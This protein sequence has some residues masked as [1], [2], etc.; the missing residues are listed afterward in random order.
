MANDQKLLEYLKRVTAD[1]DRTR[2]R[3]YE[4]VEREQEPI[5]IVGMAC[6]YP[7]GVGSP[8]DLWE[9]VDAG[10]DAIGEFPTDRGWDL[11]GLYDPD[12]DR[13]G[14]SYTRHG[15]FLYDAG[16]FDA[17]FFGISP[18]EA[19]AM[20]PQ[21]RLLLETA[22]QALE[23]AGIDPTS[24]RGSQTG[25]FAGVN[26]QDYTTD[27]HGRRPD[28]EGYLLTGAAASIASGRISYTFGLEGPAVTID[29]ACSSSLVAL[30]LACQA[31]RAGECTMAFAGGASVLSTPMVFIE[32]A[33]HHGLSVD[34]RCKAFSASADGTGWSEGAGMLLL[35][36][37]SDAERN[38]RRI[39]ALVRGSAVNQDGAS[40]GLTAP[41]GPSQRRVIRQ[42]LTNAHLAPADIDAVEGHGTGTR[43]GDPIEVQALQE[44]YGEDRPDGRPLWLG[45]LK[46]NIGHSIAAAGVGSVIKM[47]MALRHGVLPRTLHAEE[48]SPHIDWTSGAVQL[49]TRARPWDA[50][51]GRVRRAGVSSFGV[52]GTNA[53]VIV[54]EAPQPE[55]ELE[56]VGCEAEAGGGEPVL[57]LVWVVSGK[58]E[59]AL[60]AQA[61]TLHSHLRDNPDLDAAAL[62]HTL[63]HTRALFEHRATIIATNRDQALDAL[64]ALAAGQPHPSTVALS[65]SGTGTGGKTAFVCSGQG[66]QY[67]G[68]ANGLYQAFPVFAAALDEICAHFTEHLD[69]PL[70]DL[71][72]H[73]GSDT[74]SGS[75]PGE[76]LA[77]T[78]YAQPALFALQV[79]LH[80]LLTETYKIS[81]HYLAGHSLGEVTA[82]HLAGILTLPDAVRFIATRARLMQTLPPGAMTTLHTTPDTLAPQLE[83]LEDKVAIAAINTPTSL[84]ISGDPD[85]VEH[86]TTWARNQNITTKP[87]TSGKAFHS[88]HTDAILDQLGAMAG[89][90]TLH[91]PHTPLITSSDGDPLTPE[92]WARQ[93]RE[94]VHYRDTTQ[95]L[96]EH[97]VGTFIELGPDHTL[98]A[99][100]HHTLPEHNPT[101][102]TLL[103]PQHSEPA[104]HFL[105][106]LAHTT[107]PW[108][109]HHHTQPPSRRL[110]LP[111]YSFQRT[112]YWLQ[113]RPVTSS[114][115][116]P[117]DAAAPE[118]RVTS[119]RDTLAGQSP[120]ERDEALLDLVRR[121]VAAVLGH[122]TPEVVDP[123][124][125]FK[126]LGFDS[127]AAIKLRNQLAAVTGLA[128][129]STLV[130][131]HPTPMA[132]C[133]YF[134]SEIVGA[135]DTSSR[136]P[137]RAAVA[138]E[139]IAIVGMAC[140]FPGGV[141]TPDGLWRLVNDEDDAVG[142]FPTNR[143]W[144]LAALYD[145]DPGHHGTT[146]TQQ[147][148]FLYDAGEFDA[149]FFGI[150]PREALAMDPQQRLLLETAWETI[151]HAGVNPESLR[152]TPTGVFAGLIYH[153]YAGRFLTAPAGYEGYLGHGSA[154]SIASGRIAYTLG[155]EGPA[156]TV[157]TACSSSLVALHLACQA[158]RSGECTMALVGGATVMSTPAAFVEFSR[159]RGL[160]ADGRCKAFSA[161]ADGTGWGEGVGMLLVERLSDA[162]RNGHRILAVV[163]GSAVN[164]DGASN[165]LT[166]PN[167]PS[168]QRVIRQALANAGLSAADV[169]AVE[170]HGTGTKL[171]DPIEAQAL[172]ATYGRDRSE[173][174]PLWLGSLKSN[175]GHAQAAAGVGGIIK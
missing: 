163:R 133:R 102:V 128:L 170:A 35:E 89:E 145:P 71:L 114:P 141:R 123:E 122:A 130:F 139:P 19:L 33:R 107:T 69:H 86:L 73:T 1:L 171:G 109:T 140:R 87:L 36:R 146:Y 61:G 117:T 40:N 124:K 58:T 161:A 10:T 68:M 147:G 115:S 143:G 99:L 127:L 121:E 45:A 125:A 151:E 63:A 116:L 108:H 173:D 3:L 56:P 144:D 39:L 129:P 94:C 142:G 164:Q 28:V 50:E 83:G 70:R 42:A 136:L 105:T 93:A 90:L 31:L 34:G 103:N 110:D 37:L 162:E 92:Y 95:T 5:A 132:L 16:E 111:T 2:R 14:T 64:A 159:Q 174:R 153:D 25:V 168:Q 113:T 150:S 29:T 9:L 100:T 26:P 154:G 84:V 131:D 6:R 38:G 76:L 166:A 24:V 77:Q 88:P 48:P 41:N 101:A 4:V 54:E 20:D 119:L 134:Q 66:T 74:K 13:P 137:L 75:E 82:A 135:E 80:R 52:S 175:I 104:Q 53:H 7:G 60:R 112:R 43:L 47:V 160:S 152:G 81:P 57:P 11:D 72:L 172:L 55:P 118:P 51:A 27:Q 157:D 120:Q 22:W 12:P 91:P 138:D 21:Q 156:V 17:E 155:L 18:R 30:H 8:A 167:G 65:P 165:G 149:D 148:G 67:P 79:A 126:D 78:L 96:H 49:L 15:G 44:A 23:H 59:A 32:F 169:D 62:G 98:T 46:S 106:A 97:Q 85:T 158:L